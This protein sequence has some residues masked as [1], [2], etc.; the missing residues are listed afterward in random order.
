[1][2]TLS[3]LA[4]FITSKL[5]ATEAA[6]IAACKD[7]INARYRMI[8]ESYLWTE[9][10][11]VA[12]SAVTGT[13]T[14]V[15]I[16][17]VPSITFFHSVTPPATFIDFPVAVRFTETGQN[18]GVELPGY[19]WMNFFQF[20]PN[21]WNT[22][23]SRLTTPRNFINQPKDGNGYCRIK[24]VP[25]PLTAGT[26]YTLGKLRWVTLGDAD[27]PCL[28]GIDNA[29]LSFAE[30]DMLERGRQY[31]KAANKY[32]EGD[33]H[34]AIMRDIERGQQ[35]NMSTIVPMEEGYFDPTGGPQ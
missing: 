26:L 22:D 19:D 17:D 35:Q 27:A 8:Y 31:A 4:S 12:S 1:M 23:T 20:D 34:V 15:T 29:L 2:S 28:R 13:A 11:G 30:G 16:S 10:L 6:D 9:S 25:T 5:A 7:Y 3:S 33:A 24:L 21:S 18:D 14:S 32:A